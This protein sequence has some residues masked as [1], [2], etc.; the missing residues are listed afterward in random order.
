MADKV[1][2]ISCNELLYIDMQELTN[3]YAIQF[4]FTVEKIKDIN[5]VE[6]AVNETIKNNYG[7]NVYLKNN[8]YYIQ[9]EPLKIEKRELDEQDLYNS[10][11]FREKLNP[12]N[13]S[14]KVYYIKNKKDNKYYLVF[15]FLHSAMDGKGTLMFVQNV[16]NSLKKSEL[17]KCANNI[18]DREFV[19]TKNYYKKSEPKFPYI[20]HNEARKINKYKSRWRIIEIDGYVQAIVAKLSCLLAQ[21]FTND[22]IRIMIPTDIRRHDRQNNY[23]G[24][25]TLPVFL[26]VDKK[27]EISKVNGDLLFSLKNKKELNLSNTSYYGYQFMPK[28]IRKA[29]LAVGSKAIANYNKFSVGVLIS[30]LGRVNLEDYNS[31]ELTIKDFISLPIHQPLGA[32]SIVIV[33][34]SNKTNIAFTYYQDQFSEEYID[35]IVEKIKNVLSENVY[36]FNQT[37]KVINDNYIVRIENNLINNDQIA[38]IDENREYSYAQLNDSVQK[39]NTIIKENNISKKVILY[40]DRGFN[41]ISAILSCIANNITFIPIDNTTNMERLKK[42][43]NESKAEVMLTDKSIDTNIK[44][45]NINDI[46]KYSKTAVKFSFNGNQEVYD[47]YTSG[48]TGVPKCVPINNKNLNNYLSW[49]ADEYSVNNKL[50]MPLFTSESVDLTITS[51]FLPLV[52]GGAIRTFKDSFNTQV[53]KE[54]C[55]DERINVIKC[56]PTHLS[57]LLNADYKYTPKEI[58]I[59]G[60]EN[61]SPKLCSKISN[62]FNTA[63]LY[64]EYGPA[65]TTVATIFH[66]FNK[67]KDIDT[68]PIGKP[69]YNTQTIIFDNGVVTQENKNGEILISGDSV[70]D[71][72]S[73]VEKDCFV[74]LNGR[75]YYKTGDLGYIKNGKIFCVG[76][77]DNQVK[78]HANR[79][80][81]DEIKNEIEKIDEVKDVAIIYEDALY[82]FIIKKEDIDSKTIKDKLKNSLPSYMIP[83][84]I[85]FVE[86]FP[87]K[88]N[89]KIDSTNLLEKVNKKN[90]TDIT[91]ED[92]I[93]KLLNEVKKVENIDKEKTLFDLGLE[94]FDIIVYI[95]KIVQAYIEKDK[96]DEFVSEIFKNIG[97]VT[98]SNIEKTIVKYGGKI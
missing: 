38:I 88:E 91:Y 69:I 10:D 84:E 55:E 78:I 9:E 53:L 82:A 34:H 37:D 18:T 33:E 1:R 49:C 31:D 46:E 24:N 80:E 23:I 51:T 47:I 67:E 68:I 74:L 85:C 96:E 3:S 19:K 77:I 35:K 57:F 90:A 42:I 29:I 12:K 66:V 6:K 32:F 43:I 63:R 70:F 11:F 45:I 27:D 94:S 56:T 22:S 4:A 25:L 89:G 50:V 15:K 95:Q 81:L 16:M 92:E 20:K 72:Y 39:F 71:G 21:E 93:V 97:K 54:I 30:H 65:E 52:T 61:L 26:N 64:N 58:F 62:I 73:N 13:E 44:V 48:T 28:S 17:L 8:W 59:I 98:I 40:I 41:Y 83:S 75:R 60:G 5:K 87:I 7:S 86:E 76:R 79:V 14:V 36:S 2:K